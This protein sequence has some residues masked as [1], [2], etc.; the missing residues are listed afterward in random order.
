M[1]INVQLFPLLRTLFFAFFLILMAWGLYRKK[2]LV[3]GISFVLLAIVLLFNPLIV[4]THTD[5]ENQKRNKTIQND[6]KLPPKV[7]DH[8]FEKGNQYKGIQDEN[9]Q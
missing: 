8:S 9:I 3:A 2:W 4:T 7:E 1:D 5:R 6:K